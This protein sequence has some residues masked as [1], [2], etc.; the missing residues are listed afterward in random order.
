MSADVLAPLRHYCRGLIAG[1]VQATLDIHSTLEAEARA[2]V[3]MTHLGFPRT[4]QWAILD[5]AH[6]EA[7][8]ECGADADVYTVRHVAALT[9]LAWLRLLLRR[10]RQVP[11]AA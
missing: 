10:A 3:A 6:G 5:T 2:V 1:R 8:L 9:V 4:V 7:E 11:R